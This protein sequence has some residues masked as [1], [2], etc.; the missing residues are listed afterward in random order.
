MQDRLTRETFAA[1]VEHHRSLPSTND[2]AKQC[3]AEN[4]GPLPLLII[5]DQ[6]TAGRGRRDNRWWTGTGG[7]AFSLLIEARQFGLKRS[8]SPMVALAAAV[9]VVDTVR[10]LLGSHTVGIHWPNDVFVDSRKLAGVLV[11]VPSDRLY[12]VGIGIN[13]N[14]TLADAPPELRRTAATLL[15]LTGTRHDH[16]EFL[17]TLLRHLHDELRCLESSCEQ[18]SQRANALCLQ[19]GNPL[20]IQTGKQT[21]TGTCIGIGSSGELLLDTREGRQEFFSGVVVRSR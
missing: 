6:Q 20:T 12:V 18:V 9:A 10:P 8:R 3:A 16:A 15:D 1:R 4:S 14:N 2:R 17:S 11:E 5:A 21:A 13:T 19:R 7:L